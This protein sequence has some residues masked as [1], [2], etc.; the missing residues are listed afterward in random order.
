MKRK[1]LFG[2]LFFVCTTLVFIACPPK[3]AYGEIILT[4]SCSGEACAQKDGKYWMTYAHENEVVCCTQQTD[5]WHQ[6][7]QYRFYFIPV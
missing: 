3:T 1:N 6:G 2:L 7:C 5:E 4:W